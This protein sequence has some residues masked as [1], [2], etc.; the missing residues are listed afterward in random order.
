MRFDLVDLGLI[1]AVAEA[2]NIT[3]GA[4]RAGMALASAS[5]RIRAMEQAL[6]AQLF[7]RKRRGVVLTRAGSVVVRHAQVVLQ[8]L[9]RMRGEL[10][11]YARGLRGRVRLLS[12]TA[13]TLEFLPPVLGAFM[14]MHPHIDIELRE[15]P[16]GQIVR[17]I[18]SGL[19]DV[20]IVADAVARAERLETFPFAVDQLVLI[21]PAR[22]PL[23]GRRQ[24]AFEEVL[25]CDF[26]GLG[27]GRGTWTLESTSDIRFLVIPQGRRYLTAFI[28]RALRLLTISE[29]IS[30]ATLDLEVSGAGKD[31]R[32]ERFLASTH[33]EYVRGSDRMLRP[34]AG[35]EVIGDLG[36]PLVAATISITPA[37]RRQRSCS[38]S[39]P[40]AS[41]SFLFS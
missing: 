11:D 36:R 10:H 40:A 3:R 27:R 33:D 2:S 18:A 41:A 16:S 38:R 31:C 5:E 13:A 22:H 9:E 1:V 32:T 15:R 39:C 29:L 23:A 34:T 8:Q 4:A 17:A 37:C 21:T 25:D 35:L 19:A 6:G 24:I 12:N 26:V 7:D 28:T 14:S 30:R 20:G